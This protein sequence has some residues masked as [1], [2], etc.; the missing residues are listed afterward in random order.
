MG[1]AIH[2]PDKGLGRAAEIIDDASRCGDHRCRTGQA[3]GD[4]ALRNDL[5]DQ[6]DIA[7]AVLRR[8]DIG[9]VVHHRPR[10]ADCLARVRML[11]E[12]YD[13]V[14]R[15]GLVVIGGRLHRNLPRLAAIV[16]T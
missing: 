6:L 3:L 13:E 14:D 7:D 1:A 11:D 2:R 12:E 16:E 10:V 15:P 9:A 8:P 5:G 4:A